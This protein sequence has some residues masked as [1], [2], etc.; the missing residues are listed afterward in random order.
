MMPGPGTPHTLA[1]PS[2]VQ[3]TSNSSTTTTVLGTTANHCPTSAYCFEMPNKALAGNIWIGLVGFNNTPASTPTVTNDKSDTCAVAATANDTTNARR[4]ALW[5]CQNLTV[6]ARNVTI[7]FSSNVDNVKAAATEFNNIDTASPLDTSS[8]NFSASGSST[9]TAGSLTPSASNYFLVQ[10]G[11]RTQTPKSASCGVGVANCF[12]AGSGQSG[13]TWTMYSSDTIDGHVMQ[14]GP[15]TSA[16]AINPQFTMAA[17]SG[18]AS[19]AAFFKTASAGAARPTGMRIVGIQHENEFTGSATNHWQMRTEGNLLVASNG[20]GGAAY[21]TTG[22]TDSSSCSWVTTG[23][24]LGN[25]NAGKSMILYCANSSASAQKLI[26]NATSG[27]ISDY[28]AILYDIQNAATSPYRQRGYFEDTT[29]TITGATV[30]VWQPSVP[31]MSDGLAIGNLQEAQNTSEAL[32]SGCLTDTTTFGGENISGAGTDENNGW[33]HCDLANNNQFDTTITMG[34][35]HLTS[36]V[37][38]Q[39]AYFLSSTATVNHTMGAD[40][41]TKANGTL[42]PT[43]AGNGTWSFPETGNSQFTITSNKAGPPNLSLDAGSF[44]T[45][46]TFPADQWAQ[47]TISAL[48]GGSA[49]SNRGIGVMLRGSTSAHTEYRITVNNAVGVNT[50]ITKFVTGTN[51]SVCTATASPVWAVN[52]VVYAEIQG[53]TL[54]VF[55][56]G[57]G[58]TQITGTCTDSSIASGVPGVVYS[59]TMTTASVTNFSAGDF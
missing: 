10:V 32:S 6:D 20:Y 29:A 42:G 46:G 35:T 44:W 52:D 12:T 28:T 53:T 30:S 56:G 41:F 43:T 24:Q 8:T 40:T 23:A 11:M 7:T 22:N 50:F 55:R 49:G 47:V 1:S 16:S 59:S 3:W 2:M 38:A 39:T 51:T 15:Y 19:V 48:T 37:A 17:N 14:A 4:L 26:D 27:T 34:Q 54:K 45:A 13:M 31:G 58:G 36:S 18:Y 57:P 25:S 5:Y 21:T 9:V 33:W